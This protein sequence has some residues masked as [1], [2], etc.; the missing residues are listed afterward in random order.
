M[1]QYLVID[2]TN[3]D[4]VGGQ[5]YSIETDDLHRSLALLD[6][7]LGYTPDREFTVFD[8]SGAQVIGAKT[9]KTTRLVNNLDPADATILA[10]YT[11]RDLIEAKAVEAAVLEATA[12]LGVRVDVKQ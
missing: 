6:D 2:T 1:V 5:R 12:D 11:A 4:I 7:R 10:E 3:S 8:A 9:E